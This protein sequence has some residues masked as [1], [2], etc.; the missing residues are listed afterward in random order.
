M[1]LTGGGSRA[2]V[3]A[4]S[5]SAPKTLGQHQLVLLVQQ[6]QT[7]QGILDLAMQHEQQLDTELVMTCFTELVRHTAS[8]RQLCSMHSGTHSLLSACQRVPLTPAQAASIAPAAAALKLRLPHALL[9]RLLVLAGSKRLILW[10]AVRAL[11]AFA[12][13]DSRA[14]SPQLDALL[15]QVVIRAHGDA[16]MLRAA[17]TRVAKR[18]KRPDQM[19]LA[20]NQIQAK[21][22]PPLLSIQVDPDDVTC[23]ACLLTSARANLSLSYEST[24]DPPCDKL[25]AAAQRLTYC[26]MT[27]MWH[28]ARLMHI[29]S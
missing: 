24:F 29:A 21:S 25:H 18:S 27:C 17:M 9:D 15:L 14:S 23:H 4:S 7:A 22:A 20:G 11:G 12:A 10:D 28:E 2:A 5:A 3:P 8:A 13:L 26:A 1:L 19:L 16:R 6:Q